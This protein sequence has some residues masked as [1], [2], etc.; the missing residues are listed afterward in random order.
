KPV[1]YSSYP[2]I[3]SWRYWALRLRVY[4]AFVR[5]PFEFLSRSDSLRH[6]Q[7][8]IMLQDHLGVI[9][10]K[11]Q[12][13]DSVIADEPKK[14][15]PLRKQKVIVVLPAYNAEKTL[16]R[17]VA[18]I[19]KAS[20]DEIILVDDASRDRTVEVAIKIGLVVFHH[21]KNRGYGGNQKTCYARAIE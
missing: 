7:L 1:S 15:P 2:R 4:P 3:F 6:R 17:T 14:E 19:P 8:K 12:R 21:P 18:D 9:A 11:V 10:K 13:L 20:V 5:G 16:E